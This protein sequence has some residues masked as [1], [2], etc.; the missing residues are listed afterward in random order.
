MKDLIL[1][2]LLGG[3]IGLWVGV[4][5]GKDQPLLTNPF[6]ENSNMKE[7]SQ[8]MEQLQKQVSE[9]SKEI[10]QDTKKAVDNVFEDNSH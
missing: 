8:K 6:A 7:L 1:G 9:K 4:N 10:Y 2:L 3:I 5:L